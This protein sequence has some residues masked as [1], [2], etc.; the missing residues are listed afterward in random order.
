MFHAFAIVS[1]PLFLQTI[2]QTLFHT[3]A[4]VLH[5]ASEIAFVLANYLICSCNWSVSWIHSYK[6]FLTCI[7]FVIH[8]CKLLLTFT[9]ICVLDLPFVPTIYVSCSYNCSYGPILANYSYL[10]NCIYIFET[11]YY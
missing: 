11:H 7:Y 8:S 6:L 2:L 5:L 9:L 4:I 3:L 1:I 10:T